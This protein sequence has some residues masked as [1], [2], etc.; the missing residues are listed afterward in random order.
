MGWR[1][2]G[3]SFRQ[4]PRVALVLAA[5]AVCAGCFQPLYGDATAPDRPGLRDALSSINVKQID[6]AANTAEARLA[7]QIRNDLLFNFTGGG[8]GQSPTH[9]LIVKISGGLGGRTIISVDS[10]TRL[11]SIEAYNLSTTYTLVEIA[12]KNVV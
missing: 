12:T 11:P 6:A 5:A 9:E 4:W 3:A 8:S 2:R 1:E 10:Q 7:V